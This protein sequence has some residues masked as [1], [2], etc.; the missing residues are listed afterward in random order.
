MEWIIVRVILNLIFLL[1]MDKKKLGQP[2]LR[3]YGVTENGNSVCALVEDFY[4]YF[5]IKCPNNLN[6]HDFPNFQK[7]LNEKIE[8]K[9]NEKNGVKN[10]EIVEKVDFMKFHKDKQR[11]IKI[12]LQSPKLY[13]SSYLL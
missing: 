11:F 4:P 7:W 1:E 2:I 10:I 13:R 12:T 6:E 5:Y 8:Q 3:I 9:K